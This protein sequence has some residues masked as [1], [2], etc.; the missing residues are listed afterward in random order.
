MQQKDKGISKPKGNNFPLP[1]YPAD[2]DI[3]ER[4]KEEGYDENEPPA[5]DQQPEP[6]R[7]DSIKPDENER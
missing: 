5:P 1:I 3:F 7:S 4:S 2:Q 6:D